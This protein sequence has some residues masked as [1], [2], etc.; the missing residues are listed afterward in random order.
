MRTSMTSVVI[1]C[2]VGIATA[3]QASPREWIDPD[4]GHRVIR[5]SDQPGSASLYFHQNPYTPDGKKLL[6]TIP[7]GLAT[8]DL[9]TRRI[10][11]IVEGRVNVI[12]A[13]HKTGAI[14]YTRQGV[15]YATDAA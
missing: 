8:V 10:E 13:G 14:Y 5:L 15:V 9:K 4:T 3:Q 2:C 1:A 7:N 6:I 12:V 11:Q